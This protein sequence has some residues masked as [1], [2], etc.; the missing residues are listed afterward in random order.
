VT[1]TLSAK[2]QIVIP[3]EVRKELGLKPG[4]DFIVLTDADG[5]INLRPIRRNCR[6]NWLEALR[7]MQGLEIE[8]HDESIRSVEL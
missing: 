8:R 7:A 5:C 2:G 3:C 6:K 4:T 1:T